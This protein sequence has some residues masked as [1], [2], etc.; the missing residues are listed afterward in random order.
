MQ[1]APLWWSKLFAQHTD[2]VQL[3]ALIWANRWVS[4]FCFK[5]KKHQTN[6][7][8]MTCSRQPNYNFNRRYLTVQI[9]ENK[10]DEYVLYLLVRAYTHSRT[11]Q[12]RNMYIVWQIRPTIIAAS[13]I[14][15]LDQVAVLGPS[16]NLT[17]TLTLNEP[18][19]PNP[20]PNPGPKIMTNW[21][22]MRLKIECWRP[23]F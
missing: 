6:K 22:P 16:Q 7:T 19:K 23:E 1:M 5:A 17:L 3:P 15:I 11:R 8:R 18:K 9:Y 13:I 4:K 20:N 21:S 10:I 2:A 14:D 12:A